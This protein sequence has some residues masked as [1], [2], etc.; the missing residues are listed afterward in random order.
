[1]IVYQVRL[2]GDGSKLFVSGNELK[3]LLSEDW[4]GEIYTFKQVEM[5]E[6]EYEE[7][8]DFQGF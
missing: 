7:L 2:S 5:S 4:D 1:M 3:S 6:K 8:P